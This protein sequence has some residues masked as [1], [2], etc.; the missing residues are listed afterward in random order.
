[1]SHED[2]SNDEIISKLSFGIYQF[3]RL[4][5][6]IRGIWMNCMTLNVLAM[7]YLT[8]MILKMIQTNSE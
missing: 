7:T 2:V 4:S 6:V 5:Q 1:M 8:Q 3:D